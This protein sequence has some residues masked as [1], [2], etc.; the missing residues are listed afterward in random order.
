[1]RLCTFADATGNMSCGVTFSDGVNICVL[2]RPSGSAG[3]GWLWLNVLTQ[4]VA[5]PPPSPPR[6]SGKWG[7]L[8]NFFWHALELQGEAELQQAES[9]VA[10]SRA[11]GAAV[12]QHLWQPM[13]EFLLRHKVLADGIAVGLDVV[14]VIA[15][16]AFIV[17]ASPEIAG[18]AVIIGTLGLITGTSALAGSVALLGIDGFVFGC[19]VTG[20]KGRA[21]R[22]ESRKEVQWTRIGA[23]VMIL[24]DLAVG[25]VRAL[26]E[27]SKLGTEAREATEA[28][29]AASNA[30]RAARIRADRIPNPARH[31]K[32]VT[33]RVQKVN[34]F[35][36]A[37]AA[38]ARAA[39][40]AHNRIAMIA[41]KDLGVVPGATLA[42]TGLLVGAPPDILL[43]PEQRERD[44]KLLKLLEPA[45]GLPQDVKLEM[46]VMGQQ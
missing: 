45:G 16:V 29:A 39:Q 5:T 19:E 20:D 8:K 2:R 22:F 10:E 27:L 34:A 42:G 40:A 18:G 23:T 7:K 24:P 4:H 11:L 6:S 41:A 15:G 30:A 25:G 17:I 9:D 44:E 12:E 28:S 35:E 33:R 21:E 26:G 1:M 36:R 14:G 46:R 13:H 37:A 32:L 43:T 31:P 38:Q 3:S